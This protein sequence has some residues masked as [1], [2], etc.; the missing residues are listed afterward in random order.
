MWTN[1]TQYSIVILWIFLF[2]VSAQGLRF[3]AHRLSDDLLRWL[4]QKH[5]RTFSYF[6]AKLQ[7]WI[8]IQPTIAH[9]RKKI[10]FPVM[11]TTCF[12]SFA[13]LIY[14]LTVFL[15]WENSLNDVS[16]INLAFIQIP[17]EIKQMLI[18]REDVW[19]IICIMKPKNDA[20]KHVQ[21]TDSV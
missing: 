12:K 1:F 14:F 15:A 11:K 7:L 13:S 16:S 19:R 17:K 4:W 2:V 10:E 18:M 5:V 6:L 9:K 21:L 20:K 8:L 3:C